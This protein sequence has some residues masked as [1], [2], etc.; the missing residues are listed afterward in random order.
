MLTLMMLLFNNQIY[1]I[2][3]LFLKLNK[4][5]I[6]ILDSYKFQVQLKL[7]QAVLIK[8]DSDS[9]MFNKITLS[10]DAVNTYNLFFAEF[11]NNNDKLSTTIIDNNY[12]PFNMM[13]DTIKYL[14]NDLIGLNAIIIKFIDIIRDK[15]SLD[16]T[17]MKMT[18]I[19]VF[20]IQIQLT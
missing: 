4:I 14:E 7:F 13:N 10:Y 17:K 8:C 5:T 16:I 15:Y 20:L 2:T 3:T 11:I 19:S 12:K 18:T 9:W 1:K 6:F